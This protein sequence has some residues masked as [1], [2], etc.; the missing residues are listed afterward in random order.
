MN[1]NEKCKEQFRWTSS[2]GNDRRMRQLM[3][4]TGV[5]PHAG[6]TPDFRRLDGHTGQWT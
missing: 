2:D 6:C 4:S 5:T 1:T 3:A